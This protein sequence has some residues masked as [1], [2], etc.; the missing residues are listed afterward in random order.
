MTENWISVTNIERP[1][2]PPCEAMPFK[3]TSPETPIYA[4][5]YQRGT[6][7]WKF[8]PPSM[9]SQRRSDQLGTRYDTSVGIIHMISAGSNSKGRQVSFPHINFV[10]VDHLQFYSLLWL[11]VVSIQVLSRFNFWNMSWMMD[12]ELAV[13]PCSILYIH[14]FYFSYSQV[15]ILNQPI[16]LPPKVPCILT[17]PCWSQE[18]WLQ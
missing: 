11:L 15:L 10:D 17:M 2:R 8:I 5:S 1:R 18:T 16:I 12:V 14:V 7:G 4:R 6:I 13:S 3:G 9:N